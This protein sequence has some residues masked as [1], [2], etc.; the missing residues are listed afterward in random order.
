MKTPMARACLGEEIA[1]VSA[2]VRNLGLGDV[3]PAVLKAAHITTL[4]L[5]PLMIVARVQSGEPLD[6]AFQ[7]ASREIA[8]ARH[9]IGLGAPITSWRQY[10]LPGFGVRAI[11]RPSDV[12]ELPPFPLCP[13]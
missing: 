2:L 6:F 8:V 7:T 9:L 12:V 1:T 3:E 11:P 13:V 10:C 5:A 4:S